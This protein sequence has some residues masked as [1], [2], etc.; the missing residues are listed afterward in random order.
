MIKEGASSTAPTLAPRPLFAE[1]HRRADRDRA[2][3]ARPTGT[4]S[5]MDARRAP[6]RNRRPDGQTARRPD[7]LLELTEKSS[8]SRL[9]ANSKSAYEQ[10]ETQPSATAVPVAS[11]SFAEVRAS[12]AVVAG[13]AVAEVREGGGAA[14]ALRVVRGLA[15][16]A[17]VV[18]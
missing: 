6:D 18:E 2:S 14:W 17:A 1:E 13:G 3:A 10:K 9:R 5:T 12:V 8:L 4:L 7:G 15:T 16:V 11:L